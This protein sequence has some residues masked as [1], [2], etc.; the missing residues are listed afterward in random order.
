MI[1]ISPRSCVAVIT[2]HAAT[3]AG[4]HSV[5]RDKSRPANRAG[6]GMTLLVFCWRLLSNAEL[7]C[8]TSRANFPFRRPRFHAECRDRDGIR[9]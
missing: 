5:W 2:C 4:G 9:M 6:W 3:G 7:A 8:S 1:V